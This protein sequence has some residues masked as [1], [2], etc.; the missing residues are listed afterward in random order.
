MSNAVPGQPGPLV[1]TVPEPP[2][3]TTTTLSRAAIVRTAVA[4]ADVEGAAAVTMRR[5][6]TELGSSTPMSLYRYVG[7]KDGLVDLMID[8]VYGEIP[9]PDEP[10]GDWRAELEPLSRRAWS[11][12]RRHLWFGELVHTRPPLGPNALRYLD[13][14]LAALEPLGLPVREL[15]RITAALDGHLIGSALQLAEETRMRRSSGLSE[16]AELRDSVAPYL[17]SVAA[18]GRYPAFS[19]WVG[20]TTD[21]D[22]DDH[23]EWTLRCLLD[24][25]EASLRRG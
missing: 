17:S 3:R 12:I 2:G 21:T 11:V 1:W 22:L 24:G 23:V 20:A 9:V 16:E 10:V 7:S 4:V 15:T 13:F 19:R 5:V 6:S 18:S 25:I 8:A 14:R